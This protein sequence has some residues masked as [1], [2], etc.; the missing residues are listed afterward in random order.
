[1]STAATTSY[2]ETLRAMSIHFP[3]AWAIVHGEKD[4]EYR[5]RATKYRGIVIIHA[6]STKDSDEFIAHYNIPPEQVV[7][8]AIIGAAELVN[9]VKDDESDG[10]Y[11]ELENPIAF[12]E[13]IPVS[14]QQSIFWPASTPERQKAFAQAW[15]LVHEMSAPS[16]PAALFKIAQEDGLIR[17]SSQKTETTFLVKD[18]GLWDCLLPYIQN[19]SVELSKKE[20]ANLYKERIQL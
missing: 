8:K 16:E 12:P 6:S 2:P 14:G 18:E 15:Q 7:R 13:A 20:F 19:G 5:T 1:M 10:Y 9:C 11:Y 17:I 4:F 3:F